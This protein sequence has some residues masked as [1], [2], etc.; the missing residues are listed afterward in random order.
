MSEIIHLLFMYKIQLCAKH[1]GNRS[2]RTASYSEQ[3]RPIRTYDI[4]F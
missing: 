3:K 4:V 2:K 1:G